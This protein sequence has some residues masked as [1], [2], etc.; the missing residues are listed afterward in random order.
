MGN[1]PYKDDSPG[2]I[3]DTQ[4]C[5]AQAPA[6]TNASNKNTSAGSST[7]RQRVRVCWVGG[8][9]DHASSCTC[10]GCYGQA[11]YD[12]THPDYDPYATDYSSTEVEDDGIIENYC[13]E[14]QDN[15]LDY[16]DRKNYDPFEVERGIELFQEL[17]RDKH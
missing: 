4:D 8:C 17:W 7:N 12:V 6:F 11:L 13:K 5:M 10:D 3:Q 1:V 16:F 14:C 9:S 2:K 15:F